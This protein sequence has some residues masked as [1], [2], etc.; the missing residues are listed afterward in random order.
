VA[1]APEGCE[2]EACIRVAL[3]SHPEIAAARAAVEKAEAV[4]R[5]AQYDYVPDVEAYARYSF[6]NNVPFLAGN[7][8]TLGIHLSYDLFDG[9]KKRATLRERHAQLAQAKENLARVSDEVE[10]RVQTAYNKLERTRQLV[11]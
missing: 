7:F 11:A 9:G 3:E 5:L 1:D 10:L 2:R 8:G 6:Q 4:V